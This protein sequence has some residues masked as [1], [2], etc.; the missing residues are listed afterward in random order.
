MTDYQELIRRIPLHLQVLFLI[1]PI[2]CVTGLLCLLMAFQSLIVWA[3]LQGG[4]R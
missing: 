1:G 4:R 2:F 3:A